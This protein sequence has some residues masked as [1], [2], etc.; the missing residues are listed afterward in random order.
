MGYHLLNVILH[1]IVTGLFTH[2]ARILLRA[3]FATLVAG[4]VFASHPIHTEAVSGVVGRADILA[5]LFFLMAFLCYMRYCK[6]RDKN[7]TTDSQGDVIN[8]HTQHHLDDSVSLDSSNCSGSSS[9]L[10]TTTNSNGHCQKGDK[11]SVNSSEDIDCM[12]KWMFL[13]GT[14]VCTALAL[15]SKEQGITVLAVCGAY[16]VFLQSKLS[17]L[18]LVLLYKVSIVINCLIFT[19]IILIVLL[20]IFFALK[21]P[22]PSLRTTCFIYK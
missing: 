20:N 19:K 4:L 2:I 13:L 21:S 18:H 5:C 9:V 15:L 3:T 12:L 17:V 1:A 11:D 6:Y 16:D 14:S 7:L 8:G 22:N 10:T